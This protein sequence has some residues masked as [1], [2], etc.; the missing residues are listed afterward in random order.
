MYDIKWIGEIMN[1]N[2]IGIAVL[3]LGLSLGPVQTS[4]NYSIRLNNLAYAEEEQ[5]EDSAKKSEDGEKK[6]E[7]PVTDR[8]A[9]DNTQAQPLKETAPTTKVKEAVRTEVEN[10]NKEVEASNVYSLATKSEE[11]AYKKAYGAILE[12]IEKEVKEDGKAEDYSAE[13]KQSLLK[14]SMELG[15]TVVK[16]IPNR[17]KLRNLK[18]DLDQLEEAAKTAKLELPAD[19]KTLAES[20]DKILA[21]KDHETDEIEENVKAFSDAIDKFKK[22]NKLTIK[23]SKL[24]DEEVKYGYPDDFY[25]KGFGKTKDLSEV[26]LDAKIF[27][28]ATNSDD[29]KIER[30]LG[31]LYKKDSLTDKEKEEK[32]NLEAYKS[33]KSNLENNLYNLDVRVENLKSYL[34]AY[35]VAVSKVIINAEPSKDQKTI[36]DYAKRLKAIRDSDKD[37]RASDKFKKADEKLRKAY[38]DAYKALDDIKEKEIDQDAKGKIESVEKAKRDIEKVEED[39]LIS[40]IATA[41]NVDKNKEFTESENFRRAPKKLKEAYKKAFEDLGKKKTEENLKAFEEA[42][43]AI[44]D[45]DFAGEFNDKLKALEKYIDQAK[46]DN[47]TEDSLKKLK[48]EYADKLKDLKDNKDANVDDIK[49]L[50]D[51]FNKDLNPEKPEKGSNKAKTTKRLVSTKKNAGGKVRTGVESVLPLAGGVLVVAAIALVLT[52]KKN[53]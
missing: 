1:K 39:V 29:T 37:F 19:L 33:S 41:L 6:E 9:Q 50:E 28:E 46:S 35:V 36:D 34:D 51:D 52:R 5:G 45:K 22:D 10:F 18:A 2:K 17:I 4:Q 32:K 38:E 44:E 26:R 40:K 31:D 21:E 53:K 14:E 12:K 43:K 15:Y 3:L 7:Q 13:Y 23:E 24:S 25:A 27:L 42:K 47:L 49:A 48:K 20:A 11:E 16:N 8:A 30:R